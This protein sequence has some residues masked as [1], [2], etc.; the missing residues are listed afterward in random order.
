MLVT[1]KD[2]RFEEFDGYVYKLPAN[3]SEKEKED[4]DRRGA[5]ALKFF[6]SRYGFTPS[7]EVKEL[8]GKG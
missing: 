5:E 8:I 4:I 3:M 7:E 6:E 1:E 2:S